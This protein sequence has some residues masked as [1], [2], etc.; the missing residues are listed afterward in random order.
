M[1]GDGT[2]LSQNPWL[3]YH[4]SPATK[5]SGTPDLMTSMDTLIIQISAF[6]HQ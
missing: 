1:Y 6:S 4:P 2:F 5:N 3:S